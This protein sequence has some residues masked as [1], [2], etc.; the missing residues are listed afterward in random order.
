MKTLIE[1][2]LHNFV[3]RNLSFQR[4][5]DELL[6]IVGAAG[7]AGLLTGLLI[8]YVFGRP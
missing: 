5:T 6:M 7:L 1:N 2:L 3:N 8:M 4:L